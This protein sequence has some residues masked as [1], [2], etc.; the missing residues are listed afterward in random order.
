M[1]DEDSL[2]LLQADQARSDF[3]VIESDLQFIAGQLARLP[4]RG[5]LAR[6][7]LGIIFATMIL[8]TLSIL[9]L[10]ASLTRPRKGSRRPAS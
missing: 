9:F 1:P 2:T 5:E 10:F 3:A 4:T 7:A 6:A 8:T